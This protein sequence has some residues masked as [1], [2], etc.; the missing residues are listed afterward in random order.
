MSAPYLYLFFVLGL[1][2]RRE[3]E[4]LAAAFE[5]LRWLPLLVVLVFLPVAILVVSFGAQSNGAVMLGMRV[6]GLFFWVALSVLLA[7]VAVLTYLGARTL[8]IY[9]AHMPII[10][11]VV[12]VLSLAGVSIQH[13]MAFVVGVVVVVATAVMLSLGFKNMAARNI[14]RYLYEPPRLWQASARPLVGR[15][16]R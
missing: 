13:P 8:Q 14:G 5:R 7:R 3:I 11:A 16:G 15:R 6:V 10:A 1:L 9:V 2:G 4:A 12:I